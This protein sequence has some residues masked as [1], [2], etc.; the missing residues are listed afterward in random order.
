MRVRSIEGRIARIENEAF[1]AQ[2]FAE[3]HG[4]WPIDLS[5]DAR[6]WLED[7]PQRR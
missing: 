5:A 6:L 3:R 2:L 4:E 7:G 1:K